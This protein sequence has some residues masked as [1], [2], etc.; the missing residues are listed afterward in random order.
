MEYYMEDDTVKFRPIKNKLTYNDVIK[1][2]KFNTD[3]N[4]KCTSGKQGEKLFA[5][6]KLMN[7]AKYLNDGWKPNWKN[8]KEYKYYLCMS[9]D[10]IQIEYMCCRYSDI[11]YFKSEELA[12]QV[13]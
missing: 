4:T 12:Q 10:K 9:Y 7:V 5:I 11:V 6:N 13:N 3:V 1:K 2:L 8:N